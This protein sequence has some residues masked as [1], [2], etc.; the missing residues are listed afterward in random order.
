MNCYFTAQLSTIFYFYSLR[1][2]VY[3]QKG[4]TNRRVTQKS[5]FYIKKVSGK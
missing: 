2:V 4:D 1:C 3:F 5:L